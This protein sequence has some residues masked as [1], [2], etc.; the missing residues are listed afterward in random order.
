M[1][2]RQYLTSKS[3]FK[4]LLLAFGIVIVLVFLLLQWL[5]YAT[6]HG[7]EITVPDLRKLTEQ[8]VEE[9][10]DELNLEY[11]LLDTVDYNKDFPKYTV[12]QQDPLPGS[13]VKDGR[14]IYIKVN[15]A[16]FGMVTMPDLIEKTLRQT[17]SSLMALGLEVGKKTYKPYLGKDM[18]LEMYADG[19]KL[20][21][22]D[23]VK[24][25][26]KID[27]VLGDGKVGFEESET[28]T[29]KNT[30]TETAE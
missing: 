27:L 30:D 4:Q 7:N 1:T 15:S 21:V 24:K 19:K 13:K 8:Q 22:G 3:F 14:K 9:K 6:D 12:V 2:L 18:V 25:A 16:D 23:K 20:K 29:I 26:S 5:S 10:L 17:E 11:V 28:D